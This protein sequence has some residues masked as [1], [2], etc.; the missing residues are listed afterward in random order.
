MARTHDVWQ[1]GIGGTY[2]ETTSPAGYNL[3][4][5]G[6]SKYFNFNTTVGSTGY[7]IRDN[8]GTIE[9]K[10]SG[11]AWTGIGS[12]GGGTP[13]GVTTQ[14]QYND[15]GA[16]NGTALTWHKVKGA[17]SSG[18]SFVDGISTA[19]IDIQPS[20][21]LNVGGDA[22]TL[23][24]GAGNGASAGGDITVEGGARGTSGGGGNVLLVPGAGDSSA[25]DGKI[26]I[27][28]PTSGRFI[29]FDTNSIATTDKTYILP[30]ADGTVALTSDLATLAPKAS[31]TFTGTVTLPIGLTGVLRADTGVVS[32]DTDVTDLVTAASS[33]AQ[34][35]VELATDAE[36]VTGTDTA[37]ATTPANITA[38][39]SAPGPIG[40]TTAS[41]GKFTTVETT[42]GI[43]LGHAT[44]TTITR[45]AAGQIAVEGIRI[46][47]ISSTNTFTN[48][49]RTRRLTTTNAPGATPTTNTDN[50]DIMNFTGLAVAITSMTT[51]LSGTPVDGDQIEFR[52]TDNAT[53]RAITWGASFAATTIS[54]PI[55]TAIST[56]LR[57]GFEHDGT[58]WRCVAVA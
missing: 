10:N 57:V 2:I 7:G 35:K 23:R 18:I 33:T 5:N 48:K 46:P 25:N 56:M 11:G 31:P 50:V 19:L 21:T 15:A 37:R 36:A 55:T 52:F 22:L 51:N 8:A 4:I 9:F 34:G 17:L 1:T 27:T 28:N 24:A 16:F 29:A 40:N 45:D 47:T 43:E 13:G 14:I 3:L 49:R 20:T 42:G 54:L 32:I 6:T 41:T 39:M 58:V 26:K 12:G 30:N 44:D 53:A 38:K